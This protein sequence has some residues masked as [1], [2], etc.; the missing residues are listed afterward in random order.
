L[1]GRPCN[2]FEIEILCKIPIRL[3][4]ESGDIQYE[5]EGEVTMYVM[6]ISPGHDSTV[7]IIDQDGNVIV[8]IAEERL[9]RIKLHNGFP[10][11]AIEECLKVSNLNPDDIN[12]IGIGFKCFLYPD[13]PVW[14]RLFTE[15]DGGDFDVSNNPLPIDKKSLFLQLIKKNLL[16]PNS[17]ALQDYYNLSVDFTYSEFRKILNKLGF[18]NAKL[19]TFDHHFSHAASAYYTSGFNDNCLVV[20]IDGSGDGL[21]ATVNTIQN[22]NLVKIHEVK[23]EVSPGTYYSEIT[24]F[25]GFKRNRHEGKITGLAAYGNPSYLYNVVKRCLNIE[26]DNSRFIHTI[27][28]PP[29]LLRK[30]NTLRRILMEEQ[31]SSSYAA[32]VRDYITKEYKNSSKENIAAAAQ[33]ALEECVLNFIKAFVKKTQKIKI[34]LAG[35]IFANVRVNQKILEIEGV[36]SVFIHPSMGDGGTALGAAFLSLNKITNGLS[37]RSFKINNVYYG[38]EYNEK[39]IKN[40][41]DRYGLNAEYKNHIEKVIAELL[42]RKKIIGRFNGR[43]EYGPRALG[44]R[45]ILAP[46]MEKNLNETLNKRLDRTEFMPFAP[47]VLDKAASKIFRNLKAGEHP[48]YFMTI[49]FDMQAEWKKRLGAVCHVDG[50]ARPQIIKKTQNPSYYRIVEEYEKITG[51]PACVNTS[52]NMHEEP[53]VCSPDDAVR[54]YL[55]GSVDYLALGN[56]LIGEYVNY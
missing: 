2:L 33:V 42:K 22:G 16:L 39:E 28:E 50:T 24:R 45:S 26:K 48:A 15:R 44:N 17:A 4:L 53:I 27:K 43:M 55:N 13:V 8:V 25:L 35:G 18:E 52:F 1:K 41:I 21:C 32:L 9:S 5:E 47:V 36:E 14:N 51:L 29:A 38:R 11:R 56:F 30:I 31:F 10:Y 23:R 12:A 49:T 54:S 40:I 6:G 34:A 19:F 7:S 3:S 46:P 20:T 37:P